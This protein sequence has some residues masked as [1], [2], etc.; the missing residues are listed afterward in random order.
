MIEPSEKLET[1]NERLKTIY[2]FFSST[3]QPLYR[4]VWGP[5]Q[6]EKRWVEYSKEGFALSTPRIEE[7]PKY[8]QYMASCFVLERCRAVPEGVDLVTEQGFAYDVIWAYLT[9]NDTAVPP[10]WLATQV[11][12]ET[13][14]KAEHAARGSEYKVKYKDPLAGLKTREIKEHHRAEVDKLERDLFG[15]ETKENTAIAHGWGVSL[16]HSERNKEELG[17]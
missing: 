9:H 11:I 16:N 4:I 6:M 17:K 10:E 12:I 13:V 3:D 1:L 15:N 7:R 5:D 8:K 14:I 2:G